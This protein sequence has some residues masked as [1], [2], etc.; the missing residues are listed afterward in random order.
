VR[1]PTVP[2]EGALAD[3]DADDHATI[4]VAQF[5]AAE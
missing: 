1:L 5:W 2:T 4:N 3:Q